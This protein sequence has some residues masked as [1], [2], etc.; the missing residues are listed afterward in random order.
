[1]DTQAVYL[2]VLLVASVVTQVGSGLD[3]ERMESP[4]EDL[5]TINFNIKKEFLEA[6]VETQV[7]SEL[8]LEVITASVETQVG[9]ELDMEASVEDFMATEIIIKEVFL[10][11]SVEAQVVSEVVPV[12]P[13]GL[14]GQEIQVDLEEDLD[15]Q[16]GSELVELP[17]LRPLRRT[18]WGQGRVR[19]T[20]IATPAWTRSWQSSS[21]QNYLASCGKATA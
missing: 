20:R 19:T 7:G 2:E 3:L 4:E 11:A 10:G 9:S 13:V 18:A 8:C 5:M 17:L 16:E 15:I 21:F 6:S 12:G 14:E 1:M